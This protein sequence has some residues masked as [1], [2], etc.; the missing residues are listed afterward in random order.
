[1]YVSVYEVTEFDSRV[2]SDI[3]SQRWPRWSL[4]EA[5]R[6]LLNRLY[7]LVTALAVDYVRLG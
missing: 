1:M 6:Q 5:G 2:I 7:N 4:V 3:F